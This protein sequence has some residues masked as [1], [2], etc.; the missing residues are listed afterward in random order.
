[1]RDLAFRL[2]R[3]TRV[4]RVELTVGFDQ[5]TSAGDPFTMDHRIKRN[6]TGAAFARRPGIVV[7]SVAVAHPM[8][9]R[10]VHAA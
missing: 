1:M 2:P 8:E 9:H 10:L 6:G 7:F 4:T 3:T 5:Q